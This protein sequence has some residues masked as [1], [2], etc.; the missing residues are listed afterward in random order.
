MLN[1]KVNLALGLHNVHYSVQK[2]FNLTL[3][4]HTATF[5]NIEIECDVTRTPWCTCPN[6]TEFNQLNK[7]VKFDSED[8][9]VPN[10]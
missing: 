8:I 10:I 2:Q 6:A 5:F 7:V 1:T 4:G 3:D 9:I